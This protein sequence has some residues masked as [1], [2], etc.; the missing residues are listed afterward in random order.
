MFTGDESFQY[1]SNYLL[2]NNFSYLKLPENLRNELKKPFGN[3]FLTDSEI[4]KYFKSLDKSRRIFAVG[5]STILKLLELDISFYLCVFDFKTLR[6]EIS[7]EEKEK[8]ISK[9]K[10]VLEFQNPA[11]MLNRSLLEYLIAVI[12]NAKNDTKNGIKINGEEDLVALPIIALMQK[13]DIV[14]YGQPSVGLV[15]VEYSQ[16]I[17]QKSLDYLKFFEKI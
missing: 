16:K 3:V 4:M 17:K 5:D 13:N 6:Q 2:R 8:I 10:N 1:F 15:I 12:Y 7:F 9:V 14:C 11:G